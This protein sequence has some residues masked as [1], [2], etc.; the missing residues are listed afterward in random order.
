MSCRITVDMLTIR[1]VWMIA[2]AIVINVFGAMYTIGVDNPLTSINVLIS[3]SILILLLILFIILVV[4]ILAI[5][6]LILESV[7]S[8]SDVIDK[9]S[10]KIVVIRTDKSSYLSNFICDICKTNIVTLGKLLGKS[11]V[12]VAYAAYLVLL[13]TMF[14]DIM[15]LP[16]TF[17]NVMIGVLVSVAVYNILAILMYIVRWIYIKVVYTNYSKISSNVIFECKKKRKE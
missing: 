14:V 4:S 8:T 7:I 2:I 12:Q 16:S 17:T 11:I 10:S 5:F 3:G 13:G 15:E 1:A 9:I 6:D